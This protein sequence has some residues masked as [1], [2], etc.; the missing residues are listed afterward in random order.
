VE[1]EDEQGSATGDQFPW[2]AAPAAQISVS[3]DLNSVRQ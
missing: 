1:D 2:L 3:G